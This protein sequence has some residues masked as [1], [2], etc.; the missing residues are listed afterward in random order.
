MCSND[1]SINSY[2]CAYV[3]QVNDD[4]LLLDWEI[5]VVPHS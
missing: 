3:V 2:A 5:T 4:C 1:L